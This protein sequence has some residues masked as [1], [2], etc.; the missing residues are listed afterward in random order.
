M[1][2]ESHNSVRINIYELNPELRIMHLFDDY[3]EFF[4]KQSLW[5]I[6][7]DNIK[8]SIDHM[9][10]LL[11]PPA[12]RRTIE[13]DLISRS[14]SNKISWLEFYEHV[15][16]WAVLFENTFL[17]TAKT[18]MLEL[19]TQIFR[20]ILVL[21]KY[22]NHTQLKTNKVEKQYLRVNRFLGVWKIKS[23]R[24]NDIVFNISQSKIGKQKHN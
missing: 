1:E 13:S 17:H 8:L 16:E 14:A 11:C 20:K 9:C 22:S 6:T 21:Q 5:D 10:S 12:L 23:S 19:R 24:A 3:D 15:V 18:I 4:G 2:Q 7:K